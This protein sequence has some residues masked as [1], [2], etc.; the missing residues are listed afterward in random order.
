LFKK[1]EARIE[2][3]IKISKTFKNKKT[4]KIKKIIY[5]ILTIVIIAI[6]IIN[7]RLGQESEKRAKSLSLAN[8]FTLEALADCEDSIESTGN[9]IW[10]TVC[11]RRTDNAGQSIGLKCNANADTS[12][13]FT[14]FGI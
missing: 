9:I 2:K 3:Q 5:S 7:V 11:K 4:M 1:R 12:C 6:A 14:N 8:G 10:V 13:S